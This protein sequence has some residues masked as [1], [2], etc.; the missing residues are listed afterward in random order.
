MARALVEMALDP[1]ALRTHAL[2]GRAAYRER[3]RW[4]AEAPNL[5]WHLERAGALERIP[6]KE[7]P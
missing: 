6:A 4:E 1:E 2:R 5:R 3:Y 7:T